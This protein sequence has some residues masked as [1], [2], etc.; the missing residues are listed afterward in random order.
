MF[1]DRDSRPGIGLVTA[2]LLLVSSAAPADGPWQTISPGG[3]TRC[4]TGTPYTFHVRRADP[5]KL[6]I[7]F[8]GGGAC[9]SA[10]TCKAPGKDDPFLYR[11]STRDGAGNHPAEFGG[12]FDLDNPDNP[13]I[14]WSQIFVSYCTGDIHLGTRDVEYR[15]ADG[16]AFT[17]HHRGLYN[18]TAALDYAFEQFADPQRVLVAGASAGA[19]SSPVFA[20]RAADH[21]REAQVIHFAGGAGG[22]TIP[23]P[24]PL[25]K[26]WGVMAGLE[27]IVDAGGHTADDLAILDLYRIAAKAHP[28]IRFNVYDNAYD[29]VQEK[30]QSMLGQSN[31]LLPG[32]RRNREALRAIVPSL[33]SFIA[34]G[35]FHSVLRFDDLYTRCTD[36]VRAVHWLAAVSRGRDLDDVDCGAGEECRTDCSE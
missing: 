28:R 3:Q 11:P 36:G 9:W 32:L 8:N 34:G 7:F 1:T 2:I 24:A 16:A 15:P 26:Q 23:D 33:N 18:A 13:F 6:M 27:M 19:I 12:A 5:A 29:A 30:F 10:E 25:W 21:W 35:N 14:D 31:E 4:A 22:Y 20:A 17:I